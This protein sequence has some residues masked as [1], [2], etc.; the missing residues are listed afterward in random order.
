LWRRVHPLLHPQK[1]KAI[2]SAGSPRAPE[3]A[4]RK[5][6]ATDCGWVD[7]TPQLEV[8]LFIQ[9]IDRWTDPLSDEVTAPARDG[10]AFSAMSLP[11]AL[12]FV[13]NAV[14]DLP[15]SRAVEP[16]PT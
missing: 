1:C 11:R 5:L 7:S 16:V 13:P 14:A 8:Y 12:T 4:L 3:L 2:L 6:V 10:V 9:A 15:L